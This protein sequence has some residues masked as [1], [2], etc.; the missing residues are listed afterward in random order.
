[1]SLLSIQTDSNPK[2]TEWVRDPLAIAEKLS[3]I[4][5]LFERWEAR[6]P[7]PDDA[8]QEM[9]IKAYQS[10]IDRLNALYGFQSVEGIK[11]IL[12]LIHI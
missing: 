2:T 3:H 11:A 8:S 1:M 6:E 4:G 10:A 7:L 9:V 12:S 5:V